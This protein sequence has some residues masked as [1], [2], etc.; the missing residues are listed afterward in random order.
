MP[1]STVDA[2]HDILKIRPGFLNDDDDDT[3]QRER[4]AACRKDRKVSKVSFVISDSIASPEV[5]QATIKITRENTPST[6]EEKRKKSSIPGHYLDGFDTRFVPELIKRV[7]EDTN[8]WQPT[9]DTDLVIAK[10]RNSVYPHIKETWEGKH[11]LAAPVRRHQ[12]MP[13]FYD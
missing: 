10:I 3:I 1:K 12:H 7:S 8:P 13:I 6:A 2:D 11:P 9:F 4:K 5:F